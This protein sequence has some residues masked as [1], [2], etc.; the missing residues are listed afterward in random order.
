[1]SKCQKQQ[2]PK[3]MYARIISPDGRHRIEIYPD[4]NLSDAENILVRLLYPQNL[5]HWFLGT[6][7]AT[8]GFH[9][10]GSD[11][12]DKEP[13]DPED[14]AFL[15]FALPH[16][17]GALDLA[18]RNQPG[19]KRLAVEAGWD[20]PI[21]NDFD[22]DYPPALPTWV[23][24]AF[25]AGWRPTMAVDPRTFVWN[26][27]DDDEETSRD[28][29]EGLTEAMALCNF[30]PRRH[31]VVITES[32]DL[33][34]CLL[35]HGDAFGYQGSNEDSVVRLFVPREGLLEVLTERMDAPGGKIPELL[36]GAD[37]FLIVTITAEEDGFRVVVAKALPKPELAQQF[38]A[39]TVL[40]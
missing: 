34:T 26:L 32:N 12:D 15:E 33:L 16:M 28:P 20:S 11:T 9:F 10:D 13:S 4:G 30:D 7:G 2:A 22:S 18:R 35:G 31:L 38:G 37:W 25:K 6:W 8:K 21:D 40:N 1:M 17:P 3:T 27:D 36:L 23:M 29:L 14:L 39:T 24:A 19:W 5:E